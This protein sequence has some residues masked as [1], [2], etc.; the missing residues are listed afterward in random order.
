MLTV[1]DALRRAGVLPIR[2]GRHHVAHARAVCRS[3]WRRVAGLSTAGLQG[4]QPC[5]QGLQALM[6]LLQ[7]WQEQLE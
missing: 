7:Q 1:T 5:L 2:R 4:L 3:W 6:Q